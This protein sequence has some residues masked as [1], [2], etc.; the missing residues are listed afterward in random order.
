MNLIFEELRGQDPLNSPILLI[1]KRHEELLEEVTS[2]CRSLLHRKAKDHPDLMFFGLEPNSKTYSM[3]TI[4]E[5]IHEAS[6]PPFEEKVRYFILDQVD[7]MLPVHQN[8]LLKVLEEHPPFVKCIL[9]ART[10]APL[11]QTI[12]S[13]VKKYSLDGAV[14]SR[15]KFPNFDQTFSGLHQEV[16]TIEEKISF[17]EME[18][19][20]KILEKVDG[21]TLLWTLEGQRA[22]TMNI[23]KK[24]LLEAFY[25]KFHQ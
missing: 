9:L 6:L 13:R 3:D 4:R 14:D 12:L 24:H 5:F 1:S 25:A 23:K 11:L 10:S 21:A 19:V 2:F 17:M 8:A 15:P 20:E 18:S 7:A 22:E 16:Q